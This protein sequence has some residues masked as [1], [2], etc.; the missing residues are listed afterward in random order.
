M[1][2]LDN[3]LIGFGFWGILFFIMLLTFNASGGTMYLTNEPAMR[4]AIDPIWKEQ[5]KQD[6]TQKG[7]NYYLRMGK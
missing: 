4:S 1:K 2:V 6:F 3:V 7:F 5:S